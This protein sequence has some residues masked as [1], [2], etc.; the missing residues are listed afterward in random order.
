M[1]FCL[2]HPEDFLVLSAV[3]D[4]FACSVVDEDAESGQ[5]SVSQSARQRVCS[6]LKRKQTCGASP[7]GCV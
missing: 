4:L 3:A 2:G 5:G 1:I 6:I 7:P